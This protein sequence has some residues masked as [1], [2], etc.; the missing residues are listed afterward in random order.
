LFESIGKDI[1]QINNYTLSQSVYL[2]PTVGDAC[3]WL[4]GRKGIISYTIELCTTYAPED[5]DIIEELC[6]RHV[7]VNLYVCEKSESIKSKDIEFST[8]N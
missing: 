3:D 7:G 4:Y 6:I 1:K 5:P 8:I 2:Y